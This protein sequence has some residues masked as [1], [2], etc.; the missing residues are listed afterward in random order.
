MR[1]MGY[2]HPRMFIYHSAF[3]LRA[4]YMNILGYIYLHV[5]HISNVY[6]YC[7]LPSKLVEQCYIKGWGEHND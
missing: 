4:G 3:G 6:V 1:D 7:V 2:I 5:P